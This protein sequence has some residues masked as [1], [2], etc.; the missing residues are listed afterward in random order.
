MTKKLHEPTTGLKR[1]RCSLEMNHSPVLTIEADNPQQA[2]EK[3]LRQMNVLSTI[4]KVKIEELTEPA[5]PG[6]PAAR[7]RGW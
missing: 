2:E 4:H 6:R 3:F 1:F 5:R 7:P